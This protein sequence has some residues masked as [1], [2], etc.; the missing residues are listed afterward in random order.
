MIQ[1]LPRYEKDFVYLIAD[2]LVI[3]KVV[4]RVES[5]S[6]NSLDAKAKWYI[7]KVGKVE[8]HVHT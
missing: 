4:D 3:S 8:M 1:I 7:Q 2:N 6:I 5:Y